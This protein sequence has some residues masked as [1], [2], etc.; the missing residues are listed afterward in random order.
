MKTL[1]ATVAAVC[2]AAATTAASAEDYATITSVKP[3]YQTVQTPKYRTDCRM[4]EVPVYGNTQGQASTGD[5]LFGALIGGVV[6]NQFG[7]G[8]GKDAATVLGA[9][10]GADTANKNS[11]RQQIIGYRQEQTCN[12]VT[13]YETQQKI[14]NY[15]IRYEWNGIQGRTATYNNY[16]V[17][18]SIPI[19][20][21][22]QAK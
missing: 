16:R 14:K 8:K 12:N 9:I 5:T 19:H 15:T 21:S 6:G 20:V 2:L 3:N 17:G 13:F 22:I 4:N 1:L 10:I 18:D 7:G 11:S